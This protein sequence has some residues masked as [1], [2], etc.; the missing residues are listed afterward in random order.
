MPIVLESL[1]DLSLMPFGLVNEGAPELN[2]G[3]LGVS[4]FDWIA[5]WMMLKPFRIL[6]LLG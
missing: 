3:S 6:A 4:G 2:R 5:V 1:L